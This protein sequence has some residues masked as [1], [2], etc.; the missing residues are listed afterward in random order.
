LEGGGG[1]VLANVSRL[2]GPALSR[3]EGLLL[4]G[5][6]VL[7]ALG[8]K[9]DLEHYN[10]EWW[11]L[12]VRLDRRLGSAMRRHACGLHVAA[13]NHP[14]FAG[15]LDLSA[16]RFFAFIATNPEKLRDGA[17]V[18]ASFTNGSPAIVEGAFTGPDKKA[19]GGLVLLL[20]SSL[21]ADW[22][23]LPYRR[24]FVPLVD[25]LAAYITKQRRIGCRSVRLGQPVR[26]T[27]PG[28]MVDKPV[29]VTSPDGTAQTLNAV[30][31]EQ[32]GRAGVEYRDTHQIGVYRIAASDALA[33]G[34]A[35]AA[36]LDR[37]ESVLTAADDEE[38]LSAFGDLPIRIVLDRP[39][40]LAAWRRAEGPEAKEDRTE[41]WPALLVLALL[42][43]AA[44]TLLANFFTRH[45]SAGPALTAEYMGT[46]RTE[47]RL[48]GRS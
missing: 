33:S 16:A 46:R 41:Y 28:K 23:N 30:L 43:F 40:A 34:G 35:F 8:D 27:A 32:T 2:D 11:F 9:V 4:A 19:A 5:G 26:L 20:T 12:P 42:T 14:I 45:P 36:N 38:V 10:R 18:L 24:A 31:D 3:I 25:R 29:T 37:R 21:D 6:N 47:S 13:A 17:R 22:S 1:I 15:K 7:I 44:E 48:G 39:H